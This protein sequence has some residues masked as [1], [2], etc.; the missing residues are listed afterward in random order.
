MEAKQAME[1]QH[2]PGDA[3]AGVLAYT[4]EL[5]GPLDDLPKEEREKKIRQTNHLLKIGALPGRKVGKF[6]FGSK[7]RLRQFLAGEA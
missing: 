6:W 4:I 5:Y 7:R 3:I 1:H 2:E